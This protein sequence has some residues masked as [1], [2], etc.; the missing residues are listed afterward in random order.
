[1]SSLPGS[2][3]SNSGGSATRAIRARP[4]DLYDT[5][6]DPAAL[7]AWLPPAEMTGEIHEFDALVGGG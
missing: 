2:F 7:V 3:S 1:M 6:I 4:E 5:L